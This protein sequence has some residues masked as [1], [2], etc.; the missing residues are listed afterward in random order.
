PLGDRTKGDVRKL[1]S[2][3]GLP[4]SAKPD[5]QDICFVPDGNYARIVEKLRPQARLPGDIVHVD[6]RIMGRH[7][8]VLRFTVGQRRGLG[9][10][11]RSGEGDVDPLYVIRVEPDQR[12]VV[13]GPRQ[14]LAVTAFRLA[15]VNWLKDDAPDTG[16][17]P[18]RPVAVRIRSSGQRL[19]A[20]VTVEP[21]RQDGACVVLEKPEL[22]VAPGQACVVY[23]GDRVLG[24]GWI[25][26][27]GLQSGWAPDHSER[28][29]AAVSA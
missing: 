12:R 22:G 13:V 6:G 16:P 9:V 10:G 8:G 23:Q 15:E 1:A 29:P 5:S 28:V 11:G 4:V 24:G 14:A 25:R 2:E 17:G 18:A 21:G 7:D 20:T 26:R 3:L 19:A 27:D